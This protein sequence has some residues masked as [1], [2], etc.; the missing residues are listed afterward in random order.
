MK[1]KQFW[2]AVIFMTLAVYTTSCGKK[3]NITISKETLNF[4]GI[5]GQDII[6][7]K[8]DCNWF[9]DYEEGLDWLEINPKSGQNNG[10]ILINVDKN[11]T[12]GERNAT[13]TVVSESGQIR[14]NVQINQA[15]IDIVNIHDKFW[16][17][18]EYERWATDYKDDYIEDSYEHW[19]YYIG[20]EYDNWYFYFL[21]DSTGYQVRARHGDTIYYAY[22]YIYY[23][24]SDSLYINY[25]TDDSIVEDYHATIH[26]LTEQRFQFSDEFK[27]HRF[28]NLFLA[29]V[30]SRA[31]LRIDPAKVMKKERGPIIQTER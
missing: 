18:Y 20:E 14:R 22:D 30:S 13:I 6:P 2:I 8:A 16:Y 11:T 10:A 25:K 23:P 27:P 7:I 15:K 21:D 19:D 12:F 28:E 26:L 4:A 5:G 31:K 17:L 29:N 24:F 3:Q 9:I 1:T